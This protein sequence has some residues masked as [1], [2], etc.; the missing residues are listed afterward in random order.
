MLYVVVA[1]LVS[2]PVSD[3]SRFGT[4]GAV[5]GAGASMLGLLAKPMTGLI[6]LISRSSEAL[7]NTA[8]YDTSPESGQSFVID[9]GRIN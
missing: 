3:Y 7:A 4:M 5:G 2:R 6:D 9:S 8:S 1:G